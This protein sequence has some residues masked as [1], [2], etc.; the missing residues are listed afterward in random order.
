VATAR[1][2]PLAAS[3]Q[4]PAATDSDTWFGSGVDVKV[5][6]VGSGVPADWVELAQGC[7]DPVDVEVGGDDADGADEGS[8]EDVAV[9]SKDG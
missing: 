1:E 3:G 7:W 4:F 8:A 5:E 9:G 2:L 6:C